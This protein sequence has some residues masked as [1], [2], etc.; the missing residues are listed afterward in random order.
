VL[1][2][3]KDALEELGD[4]LQTHMADGRDLKGAAAVR[5]RAEKGLEPMKWHAT[6]LVTLK[7]MLSEETTSAIHSA[8]PLLTESVR[9]LMLA[10]RLFSFG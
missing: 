8:D 7:P 3:A 9:Q 5:A 1:A 4:V 2:E 10:M 6:S